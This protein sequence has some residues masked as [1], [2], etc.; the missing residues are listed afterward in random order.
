MF[1]ISATAFYTS[2]WVRHITKIVA[3]SQNDLASQS[4]SWAGFWGW[5]H[6]GSLEAAV[7]CQPGRG[8]IWCW[9]PLLVHMPVVRIHL[10]TSVEPASLGSGVE[11]LQKG[12]SPLSEVLIQLIQA[13]QI[14]S[15]WINSG[16]ADLKTNLYPQNSFA[17][18]MQYKLIIG[19]TSSCTHILPALKGRGRTECVRQGAGISGHLRILPAISLLIRLCIFISVW[20]LLWCCASFS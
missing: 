4:S 9:G 2:L 10:L 14:I 5:L 11:S 6:P 8:P 15:L 3:Y 17:F 13:T 19:V 16:S 1:L 12:H 20:Y 7:R 18:D